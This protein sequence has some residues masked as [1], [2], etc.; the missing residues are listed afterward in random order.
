MDEL[1]TVWTLIRCHI[2]LCRIWVY[3][4]CSDLFVPILIFITEVLRTPW[5]NL[6]KFSL[7]L[8]PNK[9]LLFKERICS[10][11]E[12]ILS[13]KSSA[14]FGSDNF[15]PILEA[16]NAAPMIEKQNILCCLMSLHNKY[17]SYACVTCIRNAMPMLCVNFFSKWSE[18]LEVKYHP[19]TDTL[20]L[21][22]S[23]G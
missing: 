22:H 3:T 20:N 2:L 16:I 5:I 6:E 14:Y 12:Q 21:Y 4:V 18:S 11:W 19:N 9:A 7:I 8:L 1:Q 17:F 13:F 10:L 15:F 23:L